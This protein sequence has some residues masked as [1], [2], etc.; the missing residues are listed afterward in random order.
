MMLR[1]LLLGQLLT[2]RPP[3]D[4]PPPEPMPAPELLAITGAVATARPAKILSKR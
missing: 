3:P 1:E 4:R 2:S